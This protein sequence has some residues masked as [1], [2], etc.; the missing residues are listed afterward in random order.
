MDELMKGGGGCR[1]LLPRTEL[2]AQREVRGERDA[3]HLWMERC[4]SLS[5]GSSH[6]ATADCP[7]LSP[8][9]IRNAETKL[10]IS[11]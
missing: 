10:D 2:E 9:V 8:V 7:L 4:V 5:S 11:I 1:L 3:Y 6:T